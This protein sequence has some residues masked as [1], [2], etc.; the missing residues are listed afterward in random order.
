MIM[1][2]HKTKVQTIKSLKEFL[3]SKVKQYNTPHF[4]E[5]D[6]ISIPHSFT[7]KEDIEIMGFFAAIFAWGQRKTIINKA[8]ELAHR[9][10]NSPYDFIKNHKDQDLK[11]LIGFKHRTFNDSDLLYT[12]HFLKHHYARHNSLEDAFLSND[13]LE[14]KDALIHFHNYFF[15]LP[16]TLDRT[17]KHIP[18]PLRG[19]ACKRINM[20]LRWMVRNDN[21][22]VDFGLWKRLQPHQLICPLDLHVEKT[23][24]KINLLKREKADWIAA[25]ELT[26][27]LRKL[28]AD[29]PVKYDFA[30]FAL[31]IEEKGIIDFE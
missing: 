25:M 2:S 24:R 17:K 22:G 5:N 8:K 11:S 3:D 7:K 20:Y 15:S 1:Q 27:N 18:T 28:D 26:D 21:K 9:M 29:D 30:L 31:S 13:I 12:I 4:I 6:P 19:S 16:D 14:I 10:D 23:A